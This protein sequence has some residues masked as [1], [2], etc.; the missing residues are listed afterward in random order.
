[1]VRWSQNLTGLRLLRPVVNPSSQ[2]SFYKSWVVGTAVCATASQQEGFWSNKQKPKV[3]LVE[4]MFSCVSLW[5]T[6]TC[7]SCPHLC[8]SVCRRWTPAHSRSRKERQV[9]KKNEG[10]NFKVQESYF[11]NVCNLTAHFG[12]NFDLSSR[13]CVHCGSRWTLCTF[14]YICV[15]NNVTDQ[16]RTSLRLYLL[17]KK[18]CT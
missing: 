6:K 9:K 18:Y 4:T 5:W 14:L 8:P 10:M 12:S 15:S 16:W 13:K 11:W 2:F 17:H 3:L 7:P 1:M